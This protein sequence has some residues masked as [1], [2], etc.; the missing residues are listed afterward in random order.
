MKTSAHKKPKKT[1]TTIL[2]EK[3]TNLEIALT[4]LTRRVANLELGAG[5]R[6]KLRSPYEPRGIDPAYPGPYI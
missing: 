6:I 5:P 1:R 4:S 3:V 2:E